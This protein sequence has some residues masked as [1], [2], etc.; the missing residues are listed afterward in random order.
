MTEDELID[1]TVETFTLDDSQYEKISELIRATFIENSPDE[2]GTILFDEETFNIMFGSPV[3]PRDLF[4]RVIYKPTGQIVGFAGGIPRDLSYDGKIYKFAIPAW[5]TVHP[6]HQRKGLGVMMGTKIFEL[7]K[8]LGFDGGIPLFEPEAHGI[9]TARAVAR[10]FGV[11]MKEII[12]IRKFII[13]VFN[14]RRVAKVIKLK[15]FEKLGL[16]LMQGLKK[17]SNPRVRKYK[18]EDGERLFEL[19]KDHSEYNQ[20]SLVREHDDFIWYLNQPAVN[21]VVHEGEDGLIDGF[22]VAWKFFLAGFGNSL[23]FGWL[24]L[25]HTYRLDEKEAS[26]LFKYMCVVSKDLGWGGLQCPFIPYFNPKPLKKAKFV[27]F[28]KDLIL[29]LYNL[30]NIPFPDKVESFYFDWR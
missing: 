16:F 5:G 24:D 13:R 2:G 29:G 21:C 22:V 17:T 3:M 20:L 15:W 7:G 23:P 8:E 26:D 18:Q 19:M 9:D 14:V 11:T 28:S 25:I 12:K 4:V 10:K 6:A 30:T 1:Y 27:F